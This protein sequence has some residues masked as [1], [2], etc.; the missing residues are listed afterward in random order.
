MTV[1]SPS[2]DSSSSPGAIPPPELTAR[3]IRRHVIW[4]AAI[5]A[6]GGLLYATTP[7]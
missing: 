3:T 2:S 7:G 5:T 4:A 6:L 1:N